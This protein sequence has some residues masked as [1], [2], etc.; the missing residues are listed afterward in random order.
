MWKTWCIPH[1]LRDYT[2][3]ASYIK[4]CSFIYG[5]NKLDKLILCKHVPHCASHSWSS[6]L[7]FPVISSPMAFSSQAFFATYHLPLNRTPAIG[8]SNNLINLT[9]PIP[10]TCT[11]S[12]TSLKWSISKHNW[13]LPALLQRSDYLSK[14]HRND[15]SFGSYTYIY[16]YIYIACINLLCCI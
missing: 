12:T 14:F 7:A 10:N 1:R 2:L 15:V 5:S 6:S 9:A 3:L 8:G 11:S 13:S 4:S 16:I